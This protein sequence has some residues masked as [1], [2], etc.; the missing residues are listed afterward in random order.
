MKTLKI[1]T[2]IVLALTAACGGG[3][4]SDEVSNEDIAT[5]SFD[6]AYEGS[7]S[8]VSHG[9]DCEDK[10]PSIFNGYVVA[11]DMGQRALTIQQR[12]DSYS[13]SIPGTVTSAD[14]FVVEMQAVQ[15]GVRR[16]CASQTTITFEDINASSAR[17]IETE[18]R[19]GIENCFS[20]DFSQKPSGSCTRIYEGVLPRK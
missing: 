6:G 13:K 15:V 4:G 20:F 5:V 1:T 7:L 18:K 17:V 19:V 11:H 12:T 16:D 9:D 8:R 10:R 3:G 2:L 14:S